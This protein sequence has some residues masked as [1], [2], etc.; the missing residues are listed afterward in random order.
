MAAA[1]QATKRPVSLSLS[2]SGGEKDGEDRLELLQE[3]DDA[4]LFELDQKQRL[5]DGEG[6]QE[7]AGEGDEEEH[8][9]GRAIEAAESFPTAEENRLHEAEGHGVEEKDDERNGQPDSLGVRTTPSRPQSA[10][11]TQ[12]ARAPTVGVQFTIADCEFPFLR[13]GERPAQST[14]VNV[15]PSELD[16]HRFLQGKGEDHGQDEEDHHPGEAPLP[17]PA[18][19]RHGGFGVGDGDALDRTVRRA[20]VVRTATRVGR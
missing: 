9:P 6:A 16:A 10:A 14:I 8:H 11:A 5:D 3:N 19:D 17:A 4:E 7:P 15:A 18:E 20:A 1:A 2:S 13:Y 12:M